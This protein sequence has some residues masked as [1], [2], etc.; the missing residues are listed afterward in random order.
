MSC[1]VNS[2]FLRTMIYIHKVAATGI[3]GQSM[4]IENIGVEYIKCAHDPI[5]IFSNSEGEFTEHLFSRR[6]SILPGQAS[7][8][9][10]LTKSGDCK[11]SRRPT[12]ER[13]AP[14]RLVWSSG[15]LPSRAGCA[16]GSP[17][18]AVGGD[19]NPSFAAI[20][21]QGT[22]LKFCDSGGEMLRPS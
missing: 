22:S 18:A 12:R 2:E 21:D 5:S 17:R 10:R 3:G 14:R 8:R 11:R 6:S 16:A 4:N 20:V 7:S 19:Y 9:V 15:R 13:R 1:W